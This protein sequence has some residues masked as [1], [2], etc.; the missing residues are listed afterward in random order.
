MAATITDTLKKE[1]LDDLFASYTGKLQNGAIPA[2]APDNYYI[3]IG[4]AE[5]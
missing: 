4:K 5:Q 2:V 1:L 3:G